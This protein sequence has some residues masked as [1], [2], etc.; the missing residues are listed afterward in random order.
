[1]KKRTEDNETKKIL[2]HGLLQKAPV[3]M[4][5][6]IMATVA[7]SPAR[8]LTTRPIEP[9]PFM[10]TLVPILTGILVAIAA[11]IKPESR[12]SISW[13]QY[14]NL[15]INPIWIAPLLTIAFTIWG[16]IFI[17]GRNKTVHK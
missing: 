10:A 8:R 13:E 6:R 1:M 15:N 12:F 11:F 17:T 4:I 3:G 5:D 9:K 14:L 7:V 16:Y 2:E